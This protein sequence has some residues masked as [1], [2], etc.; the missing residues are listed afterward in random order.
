[1]VR[2][3]TNRGLRNRLQN[4][5]SVTKWKTIYYAKIRKKQVVN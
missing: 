2:G 5:L 4:E 1:M 3:A